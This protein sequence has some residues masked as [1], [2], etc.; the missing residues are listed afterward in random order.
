MEP[1]GPVVLRAARLYDGTGGPPVDGA[2]ILVEGNRIRMVGQRDEVDLP[3]GAEVID[4]GD[5]SLAPGLIDAHTHFN[6]TSELRGV[7]ADLEAEGYR[8]LHASAEARRMLDAGITAARCCGSTVGPSLRRAIEE[9]HV[10]GPRLVAAGDF[11]CPTS[12]TWDYGVAQAWVSLPVD[13]KKVEGHLADGADAMRELVRRRIRTGSNLI[14]IGT[15]RGRWDT[16]LG[17]WGD[18]P[19]DEAQVMTAEELRAVVDEAHRYR[20][21]VACH[22]IGDAAVAAALDAGVDTIE[23]GMAISDE[24]RARLVDRGTFVITTF[25][26]TANWQRHPDAFRFSERSRRGVQAHVDA[27]RA[28]LE[29]GLRAGVRF[30]LGSDLFGGKTHPLDAFADEFQLAVAYGMTPG[31]ALHAGTSMSAQAIGLDD[32]VGTIEPGRLADVIAVDGDPGVDITA[33]RRVDFVMQDG[34]TVLD[35]R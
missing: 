29:A 11:V 24:T 33:L 21:R 1:R 10:A 28:A 14:K 34:R 3:P 32:V 13:W 9:G 31:E 30:A 26:C 22:A 25:L 17:A 18:D 8:A 27:Q 20:V 15:S 5:R 7:P 19:W 2:A 16:P 35:R 23:H 12:G 6:G 4:L